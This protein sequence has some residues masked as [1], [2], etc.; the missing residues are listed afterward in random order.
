LRGYLVAVNNI[1]LDP[2]RKFAEA[3]DAIFKTYLLNITLNQTTEFNNKKVNELKQYNQ[4]LY[5]AADYQAFLE[6]IINKQI[7]QMN[8]ESKLEDFRM[9]ERDLE[10]RIREEHLQEILNNDPIAIPY[11]NQVISECN[12]RLFEFETYI[13]K[14][15]EHIKHL[16]IKL[17]E[18]NLL[19]KE[20]DKTVF[21]NIQSLFQGIN[22]FLANDSSVLMNLRK[23]DK[24]IDHNEYLVNLQ[25][26]LSSNAATLTVSNLPEMLL[27]YSKQYANSKFSHKSSESIHKI[28][29]GLHDFISNIAHVIP[30]MQTMYSSLTT[31][32][33]RIAQAN[34]YNEQIDI[35]KQTL[36]KAQEDYRILKEFTTSQIKNVRP[37][38]A[39][40]ISEVNKMLKTADKTLLE[41]RINLNVA[42]DFL[43][44]ISHNISE[45]ALKPSE[46]KK[47]LPKAPIEM[48]QLNLNPN[49]LAGFDLSME[50]QFN[51][52]LE[53]NADR[54]QNAAIA[55]DAGLDLGAGLVLDAGLDFDAGLNIDAGLNFNDG[56]DLKAPIDFNVGL[57][58]SAGI[59]PPV[60]GAE[61]PEV[62]GAAPAPEAPPPAYD[63]EPVVPVRAQQSGTAKIA[64]LLKIKIGPQA[65]QNSR[66]AAITTA[67]AANNQRPPNYAA[68]LNDKS[69]ESKPEAPPPAY[70]SPRRP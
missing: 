28:G 26:H 27:N 7:Q 39:T 70:N 69:P 50:V 41:S 34:I 64:D 43:K 40:S 54:L 2:V 42:A 11:Q 8:L 30:E 13:E 12:K 53:A 5:E 37:M 60:Y 6:K 1:D 61:Q 10:Q 21:Q 17:N 18:V 47:D 24:D 33:N 16:T 29:S 14:M 59:S 57:D 19:I 66:E 62:E 63:E 56:L 25:D 20:D 45:A 38:N 3:C 55:L 35:T 32:D 15:Q 52:G 67:N 22:N 31:R 58:I 23:I 4:L 48:A 46:P 51:A 49:P 36:T 68:S 9:M 65:N 44:S